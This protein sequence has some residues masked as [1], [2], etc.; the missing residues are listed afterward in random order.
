[1]GSGGWGVRF[2]LRPMGIFFFGLFKVKAVAEGARVDTMPGVNG[3]PSLGAPTGGPQ[4]GW[5]R[6]PCRELFHTKRPPS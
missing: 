1:M 5:W 6:G 2:L 3:F 4:T